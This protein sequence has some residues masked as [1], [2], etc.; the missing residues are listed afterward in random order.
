M[1][2]RK[3][4]WK[5][6]STSEQQRRIAIL[7]EEYLREVA[8]V[9]IKRK[10]EIGTLAEKMEKLKLEV[11]ELNRGTAV[12]AEVKS[13]KQGDLKSNRRRL[14]GNDTIQTLENDIKHK[15]AQLNAESDTQKIQKLKEQIEK[16]EN[17]LSKLRNS[18]RRP[19]PVL[20]QF[21]HGSMRLGNWNKKYGGKRVIKA[22]TNGPYLAI[23]E[24][25]RK[26]IT[27][28]K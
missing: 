4:E 16:A 17:E 23:S 1:E 27:I 12:A 26:Q 8:T 13:V 19:S 6:L 28:I 14:V 22:T 11:E 20:N 3:D 15:I 10:Q 2:D 21:N 9:E 25:S 7:E 24:K 18:G 5:Q